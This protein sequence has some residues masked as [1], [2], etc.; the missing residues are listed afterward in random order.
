MDFISNR[1]LLENKGEKIGE[2]EN[3]LLIQ[4]T[5]KILNIQILGILNASEENWEVTLELLNQE[6]IF[7]Y[8]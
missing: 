3:L 8:I 6:E 1:L 2:Y 7:S 4:Y 5:N